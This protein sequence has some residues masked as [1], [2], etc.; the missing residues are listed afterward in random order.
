[1][2]TPPR[3]VPDHVKRRALEIARKDSETA[4][5]LYIGEVMSVGRAQRDELYRT[6]VKGGM[7]PGG[8][9]VA[10]AAAD[11]ATKPGDFDVAVET[12]TNATLEEAVRLCKVD[13]TE[14]EARGFSV[15]RKKNAFGWNARFS[16]KPKETD[17]APM[18]AAFERAAAAVAPK[19][20]VYEKAGS[21]ERDCLY[22][23]NIQDV[24]FAKLAYPAE[25]GGA[26]WDLKLSD[27]AFRDVAAEL[28]VKAP[29][30]RIEEVVVIVGSDMLQI[31][32]NQS[33]TT[34]GTYVDS[35]SRLSKVYD[36]ATKAVTDVIEKLASRF[37]VRVVSIPGNHDSTVSYFL[38]KHVEV[39]FRT[40]PNVVVDSSPK[41]RKYY[42]YGKTLI[43]FDHG[44]NTKLADLPLIMMRENQATISGYQHLE[45]LTGDKHHEQVNDI[46]G[47]RVRI[48]PAICPPDKWH[49]DKGYVGSIRQSQGLLYN[50]ER[51]LEAIFYSTPLDIAA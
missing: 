5:R 50:R 35:D 36:V 41:S 44:C 25:T 48:A 29:A 21:K 33:E 42:G 22:V 26:P 1:M 40:H 15:T 2:P 13:L 32:N 12:N 14:W 16:R 30:H 17:I 47:V 51:G 3:I 45:F 9:S 8:G 4:A 38:G 49:A 24:H 6:Q 43:G 23:L 34:A 11:D 37:K 39:F 46:K 18:I 10:S 7:G 19:K 28:I 20:W 27:Q 31:D